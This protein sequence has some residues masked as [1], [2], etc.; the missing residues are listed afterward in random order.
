MKPAHLILIPLCLIALAGAA[1]ADDPQG[2]TADTSA[3]P[4][5]FDQVLYKGLV[6]SVLDAVPMS[7]S[8]RLGLQRTNAVV[9]N[10]LF[11]HSLAVLVGF[12]NPVLLLGGFA[13]GMWAAVNI[14]PA[15]T[16][17]A[18]AAYPALADADAGRRERVLALPLQQLSSAV[19]AATAD[20]PARP[21]F[22]DTNLAADAATPDG[23]RAHVIKVR[24]SQREHA[25][26]PAQPFFADMNLAADSATPDS[27]RA[28]VIKVRRSLRVRADANYQP[29]FADTN[30]AVD[31]G[32]TGGSRPRV[33]KVW[34]AQRAPAAQR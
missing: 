26:A 7:S 17:A 21:F 15:E 27:S 25:D 31:S 5:G 34:L 12:S 8:D 28:H 22:A 14:H 6:G 10:T 2:S 4:Q 33:I 32:T 23:S 20:A 1:S 18:L 9:S 11:G 3:A 29:F 19:E 24:L 30:S 16:G 13:W